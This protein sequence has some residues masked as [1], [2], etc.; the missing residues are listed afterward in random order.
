MSADPTSTVT[1][2]NATTGQVSL[3][4]P[5][6][7]KPQEEAAAVE[8]PESIIPHDPVQPATTAQ[9]ETTSASQDTPLEAA[10]TANP[11]QP[12]AAQTDIAAPTVFTPEFVE[13]ASHEVLFDEMGKAIDFGTLIRSSETVIVVFSSWLPA[14]PLRC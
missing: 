7:S 4:L 14:Q 12:P 1:G 6:A 9:A 2:L 13:Q 3:P 5:A 10:T 11:T 8:T